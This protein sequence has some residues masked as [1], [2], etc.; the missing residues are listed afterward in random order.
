M[1]IDVL[2]I[3]GKSTGRQVDLPD[4]IFGIE[5]NNHA[6]YLDVKTISAHK[7]QGT[8]KTK[9]RNEITGSTRKVKK[10]KGT[11]TARMGSL[12]SPLLR[13]GGRAFGPKPRNYNLKMNKKVKRLARMSALSSK[14]AGGCIKVVEDFTFDKPRTKEFINVMS[15]LDVQGQKALFVLPDYDNVLLMSSRNVQKASVVNAKDINTYNIMN[16]Q[17][18]VL[19]E[20]AVDKIKESFA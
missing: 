8:H 9:E 18:L 11:G 7:R 3:N 19:S 15:S 5:P 14:A 1:K 16:A 17:V 10:Q 13:S 12:K 2:G 6:I 20:G 4:N